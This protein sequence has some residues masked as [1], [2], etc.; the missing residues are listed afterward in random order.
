MIYDR[1]YPYYKA[2]SEKK[3]TSPLSKELMK[4][5]ADRKSV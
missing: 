1:K 2:Y 5:C 4:Q 3:R